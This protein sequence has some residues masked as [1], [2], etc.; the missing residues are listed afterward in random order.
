MVLYGFVL[1]ALSHEY[2]SLQWQTLKV[3]KQKQAQQQIKQITPRLNRGGSGPMW[4][5]AKALDT[6][7]CSCK[8]GTYFFYRTHLPPEEFH[9]S[10]LFGFLSIATPILDSYYDS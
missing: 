1:V 3:L 5:N 2:V 4:E 10:L 8:S 9:M 6:I 7:R